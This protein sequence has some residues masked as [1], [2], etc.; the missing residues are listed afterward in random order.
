MD[1]RIFYTGARPRTHAYAGVPAINISQAGVR[2]KFIAGK[3]ARARK[4]VFYI[5]RTE[6]IY[7]FGH[8]KRC[9]ISRMRGYARVC[10]RKYV[11][12]STCTRTC[13]CHKSKNSLTCEYEIFQKTV[14]FRTPV[15]KS[16]LRFFFEKMA[17]FLKID[18]EKAQNEGF[19]DKT[20]PFSPREPYSPRKC[21]KSHIF[22]IKLA[23]K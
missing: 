13:A 22:P 19:Y 23:E 18:V 21:Q 3:C 5:A 20:V 6:Y 4:Y 14:N 17:T 2:D 12:Y 1:A 7:V 11:S 15:K 16:I 8:E 10:S 9:I